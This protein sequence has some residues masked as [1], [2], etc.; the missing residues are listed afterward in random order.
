V[1]LAYLGVVLNFPNLFNYQQGTSPLFYCGGNGFV[2]QPN[3]EFQDPNTGLTLKPKGERDSLEKT[4]GGPHLANTWRGGQKIPNNPSDL[5]SVV[6]L[7]QAAPGKEGASPD[8]A[9]SVATLADIINQQAEPTNPKKPPGDG[10]KGLY[11]GKSL[12]KMVGYWLVSFTILHEYMHVVNPIESKS[13]L[14]MMAWTRLTRIP[15]QS[16]QVMK[17]YTGLAGAQDPPRLVE[18]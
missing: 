10:V 17:K 1:P 7:H 14:S 12:D 3:G 4:D 6:I 2:K 13:D 5:Q 18:R 8:T 11:N 15:T 9:G 16:L